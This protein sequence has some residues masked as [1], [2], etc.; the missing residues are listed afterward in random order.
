MSI[1][2][3]VDLIKDICGSRETTEQ[4]LAKLKSV[5]RNVSR[6]QYCQ[7][8]EELCHKLIRSYIKEDVPHATAKKLATKAAV[9]TLINIVPNEKLIVAKEPI[10]SLTLE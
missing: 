2:Q 10:K 9:N 4:A 6:H 3:I 1:D 7:E 8:I 5:K